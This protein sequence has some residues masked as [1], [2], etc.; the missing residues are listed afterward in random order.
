MWWP[1]RVAG[2][3]LESRRPRRGW[4]AGADARDVRR[5]RRR[6]AR[7]GGRTGEHARRR[8]GAAAFGSQ[9]RRAGHGWPVGQ[10]T[11]RPA[12]CSRRSTRAVGRHRSSRPRSK[13]RW[14]RCA[15]PVASA[16][17]R[18]LYAPRWHGPE[19][20]SPSAAR[21]SATSSSSPTACPRPRLVPSRVRRELRRGR[22]QRTAEDGGCS[23]A[24]RPCG[25]ADVGRG[26]PTPG[27]APEP[28]LPDK[29]VAIDQ[30]AQPG[31][32]GARV[33]WSSGA[34]VLRRAADNGRRRR[35]RLRHHRAVREGGEGVRQDRGRHRGPRAPGG[36][37]RR[38]GAV[39]MGAHP[40]RRVL[41]LRPA[42]RRDARGHHTR[43][44][45]PRPDPDPGAGAPRRLQ[46]GV[47]SPE[48]LD[49]HPAGTGDGGPLRRGGGAQVARPPRRR[50]GR[51]LPQARASDGGAARRGNSLRRV[52]GHREVVGA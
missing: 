15:R 22:R 10:P 44:L 38:S 42:P 16:R 29:V 50:E 45:R 33:R 6:G 9:G 17:S 37:A 12:R 52:P 36:D 7:A 19:P 48:G 5:V 4:A 23:R 49:R 2:T 26:A 34:R 43:A 39:P 51:A 31:E 47:R 27:K 20:R 24:R 25:I 46:G 35:E 1:G 13:T 32:G 14:A 30:R 40:D 41:L 3:R 28:S 8:G 21:R 11:G 18:I